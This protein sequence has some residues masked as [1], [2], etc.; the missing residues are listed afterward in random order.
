MVYFLGYLTLPSE[1]MTIG[2]FL[3]E[4]EEL[5]PGETYQYLPS[6]QPERVIMYDPISGHARNVWRYPV[7]AMPSIEQDGLPTV[8]RAQ[9]LRIG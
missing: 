6:I 4:N 2:R 9:F 3:G 1:G 5:V 7:P 8:K